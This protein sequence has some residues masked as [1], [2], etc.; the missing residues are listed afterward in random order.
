MD[1]LSQNLGLILGLYVVLGPT[2]HCTVG[3]VGVL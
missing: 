3:P 1:D 2:V